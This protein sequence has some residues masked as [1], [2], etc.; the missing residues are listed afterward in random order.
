MRIGDRHHWRR[1]RVR[2]TL[3]ALVLALTFD[4]STAAMNVSV[5]REQNAKQFVASI[6]GP[7]FSGH[8]E[9]AGLDT[10]AEYDRTFEPKLAAL[11]FAKADDAWKRRDLD[12]LGFDILM[13]AR[14]WLATRLRIAVVYSS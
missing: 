2:G 8:T 6:Y 10:K 11:L 5:A 1:L 7:Y 12:E 3:V 14:E 4:A 9:G 13:D